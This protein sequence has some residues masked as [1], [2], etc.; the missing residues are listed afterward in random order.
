MSFDFVMLEAQVPNEIYCKAM[1]IIY[2]NLSISNIKTDFE[3]K[4]D[5]S[6]HHF[7]LSE[8]NPIS[9]VVAY[10]NDYNVKL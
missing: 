3:L 6:I 10:I 4:T 1:G 9:G 8:C 5:E 7:K 2:S